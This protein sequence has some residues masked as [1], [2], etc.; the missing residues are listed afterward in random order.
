[1]MQFNMMD[2][3]T[4]WGQSVTCVTLVPVRPAPIT[5][6]N[7]PRAAHRRGRMAGHNV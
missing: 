6:L 1:M 4:A 7:S 5:S 2:Q 3:R